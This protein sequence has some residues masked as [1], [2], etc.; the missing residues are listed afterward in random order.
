[1]AHALMDS[2]IFNVILGH[3]EPPNVLNVAAL[4]EKAKEHGKPFLWMSH[5]ANIHL[6]QYLKTEGLQQ[7][8]SLRGVITS[9]W[10]NYPSMNRI[11][12]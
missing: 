9:S 10:L 5:D 12:L 4:L 2:P 1:M 3:T 7:R 11:L 8:G 6:A